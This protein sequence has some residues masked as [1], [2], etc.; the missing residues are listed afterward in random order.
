VLQLLGATIYE[1]LV[2]SAYSFHML[3]Y[4]AGGLLWYAL[5]YRSHY[6]PRV[7]PLFGLVAVVLALAGTVLELLGA[8]VPMVVFLPL[9]PFELTIGGWLLWRGIESGTSASA[10]LGPA[11][12]E[13]HGT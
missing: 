9:L 3:F 1:G 8:S 10:R 6:L 7:V 13:P 4:C 2:R 5:F 11:A 12:M